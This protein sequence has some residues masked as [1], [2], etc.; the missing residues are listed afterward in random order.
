MPSKKSKPGRAAKSKAPQRKAAKRVAKPVATKQSF[1][2]DKALE[3]RLMALAKQM[4][5]TLAAVMIQALSEFADAWEDHFQ[6]IK[7]LQDDDRVQ[8]SVERE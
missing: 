2:V 6:T 1:G 8:L 7:G 4:D 3:R 5:K